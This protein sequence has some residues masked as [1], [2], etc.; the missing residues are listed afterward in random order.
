MKEFIPNFHIPEIIGINR[1]GWKGILEE[2]CKRGIR[3]LTNGVLR[4]TASRHY[5]E[6][7]QVNQSTHLDYSI[8]TPNDDHF[9]TEDEGIMH[10][11]NNYHLS[12]KLFIIL[13]NNQTYI[14]II[15]TKYFV[16]VN[17]MKF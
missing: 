5:Q 17:N 11:S 8:Q 7:F 2:G 1:D 13:I 12:V 3:N 10:S 16:I 15:Y 14:K 6:I 9:V 4:L